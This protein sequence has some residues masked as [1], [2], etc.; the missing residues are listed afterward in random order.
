MNDS[1]PEPVGVR[2]KRLKLA[3]ASRYGSDRSS[4]ERTFGMAAR[5]PAPADAEV[6]RFRRWGAPR[7]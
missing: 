7:A 4:R 5:T 6:G 2:C 1:A 3:Y